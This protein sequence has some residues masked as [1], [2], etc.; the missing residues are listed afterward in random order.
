MSPG[1]SDRAPERAEGSRFRLADL[2]VVVAVAAIALAVVA[3]AWGPGPWAF[4]ILYFWL[5]VGLVPIAVGLF[6]VLAGQAVR[7]SGRAGDVATGAPGR[8][9]AVLWRV[10]WLIV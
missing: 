8:A 10:V 1:P 9:G 4:P 7:R 5:G 3:R 2:M 6:A